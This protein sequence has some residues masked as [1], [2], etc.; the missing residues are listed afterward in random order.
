MSKKCMLLWHE[1]RSK[2][3]VLKTDG[4]RPVLDVQMSFRV[5][6]ARDSVH[7]QKRAKCEGFCYGRRGTFEE[8][9]DRCCS[10]GRRSTR[11][12]LIRDIRRTGH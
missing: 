1:A 6:G 9:L 3:K 4:L 2:S 8:D 10:R 11:D 5:A 12:M 7:C